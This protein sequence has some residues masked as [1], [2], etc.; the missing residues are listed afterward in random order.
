VSEKK[1]PSNFEIL[2]LSDDYSLGMSLNFCWMGRV[3]MNV[4][5]SVYCSLYVHFLWGFVINAVVNSLL[6]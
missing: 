1:Q 5:Q 4:I 6:N 3:S 2:A